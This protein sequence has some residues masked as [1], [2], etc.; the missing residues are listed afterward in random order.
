MLSWAGWPPALAIPGREG[1]QGGFR[2]LA[3]DR[4][5]TDAGG[6]KKLRHILL[7]LSH[8]GVSLAADPQGRLEHGDRRG[9]G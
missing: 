8:A 1:I 2:L 6:P 4:D 7:R 5:G 9:D 3:G